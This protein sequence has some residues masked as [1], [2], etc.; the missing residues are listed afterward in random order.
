VNELRVGGAGLYQPRLAGD[1]NM[2]AGSP[3]P[4]GYG[5]PTGVTNPIHGGLPTITISGFSGE[6]GSGGAG[7]VRGPERN[8]DIVDHVSYVSG[9]HSFMFGLE[10][11]RVQTDGDSYSNSQGKVAFKSLQNFLLGNPASSSIFVGD[12]LEV[13]HNYNYAVFGQDDWRVATRLTLNLGLRYE[14]YTSPQD[15]H[16]YI[17]NFYANANPATSPA[18]QQSGGPFQTMY[19]PAKGNVS[20]RFGLAWDIRGNGRTVLRGGA[21]VLYNMPAN[22]DLIGTVP[23]GANFPS[24][25]VNNSGTAINFNTP[26]NFSTTGLLSWNL[27]G[28]VFPVNVPTVVNGVTYTGTTCTPQLPCSTDAVSPNL[29]T[30][31]TTQWN[32]DL[33]RAVTNN[34]SVEVAYVGN[35]TFN[36]ISFT[37]PDINQPPLGYGWSNPSSAL[38]GLSPAADCAAS[39]PIYNNCLLNSTVMSAVAANEVAGKTYPEYPYLSFINQV[40]NQWYS[41]YNGLQITVTGRGYHGLTF[42][43]GYTLDS[44]LGFTSSSSTSAQQQDT[45]NASLNYGPTPTDVN[46]RFTFSTTYAIPGVRAPLQILQGWQ[47]SGIVVLQGGMRWSPQDSTSDIQGTGEY[48]NGVGQNW[49]YSGPVSAFQAGP[50]DIPCFGKLPGCTATLPS[51]CMSAAVAPYS[52]NA[53]LQSLAM[54]AL[55]NLGCYV[56]GSGVLTPPAYGTVGNATIGL[57]RGTPYDNLDFSVFKDFKFKERV[58]AEFRAEFYNAFNHPAFATPNVANPESGLGFGCECTTADGSDNVLGSGGPRSIQLGLK[59]LF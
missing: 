45:Y 43:A 2:L 23:F 17:G 15:A 55:T 19:H 30:P 36:Q 52:G 6:L 58:T 40:G 44:A 5:V 39:T 4:S 35:H 14:Y 51:A 31:Y 18:V 56:Q 34:L 37:G 7:S 46:N 24:I 48:N 49:N 11:M 42:I 54:A 27:T 13:D 21:S 9:Q 59:F 33:Q 53:Q 22:G 25:G 10:W 41:S 57:F 8:I 32:V 29:S 47:I 1:V 12:A 26:A 28:P 20:P 38:G 50:H 3:W 16:N